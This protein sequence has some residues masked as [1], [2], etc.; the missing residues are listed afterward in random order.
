[1]P[2]EKMEYGS[3]VKTTRFKEG[4]DGSKGATGNKET[5]LGANCKAT[6]EQK[7]RGGKTKSPTFFRRNVKVSLWNP[8]IMSVDFK[9]MLS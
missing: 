8:P 1:M 4:R 7:K 6:I 5:R 2:R 9:A 3:G